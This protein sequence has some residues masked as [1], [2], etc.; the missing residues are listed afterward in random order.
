MGMLKF[1]ADTHP[2]R[3]CDVTT[4]ATASAASVSGAAS[5]MGLMIMTNG[6]SDLTIDVYDNDEASGTRVLP[7][8]TFIP[9]SPKRLVTISI[10]PGIRCTTGIYVN[11]SGTPGA[12]QVLYDQG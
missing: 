5:F 4:P 12:Y 3:V 11:V 6:T 7:T 8:S 2:V 9:G 10:D 1:G